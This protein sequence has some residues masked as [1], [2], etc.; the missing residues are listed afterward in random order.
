MEIVQK[1]RNDAQLL[2]S[3]TWWW[4]QKSNGW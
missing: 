1:E 3:Y 2:L 4:W